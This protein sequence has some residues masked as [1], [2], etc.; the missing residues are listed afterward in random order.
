[1]K[2]RVIAAVVLLPLLLAILLAAPKIVTAVLFGAMAAIA[3]FELLSAMG[4]QKNLRLV[5]YS[6]VMALLIPLWCYFGMPRVWGHGMILLFFTVL[7]VEMMRSHIK[8][9]FDK[10]VVCF[11]TATVIPYLLSSPV[12]ILMMDRAYVMIPFIA[13]FA[14]DTGAYFVGM[15][16]GHRKLAP[17]ISPNKTV[18]GVLGG[19]GSAVICM[20]VYG[21][22]LQMMKYKVNYLLAAL[23]GFLGALG[24]VFG[25]LCF[26]V[27][28][29]QTG[30]KDYG[31]LIPGH[32]G[33]LDRFDSMVVA[34]S[35]I[36]LLLLILPMAV[37]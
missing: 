2:T 10:V 12:R 34:G 3:A 29:R 7:F 4:M 13:A 32:G 26:S 20:V 21:L 15:K 8:L 28:K 23:Y 25:D 37:K 31:N 35:V 11:F 27:I 17:V 1:M 14:S 22:I 36:E 19:V 33:I 9:R 5:I 6:M 18:E 24:G 30:L 16:F